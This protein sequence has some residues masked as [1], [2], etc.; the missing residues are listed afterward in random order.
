MQDVP[1]GLQTTERRLGR[2][3]H[4]LALVEERTYSDGDVVAGHGDVAVY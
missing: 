4:Q 2:A 1:A 3:T